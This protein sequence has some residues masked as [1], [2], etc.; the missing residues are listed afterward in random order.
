MLGYN[1]WQLFKGLAAS[2]FVV[3]I[4]SLLL[5][6]FIPAPPSKVTMATLSKALQL[7]ITVGNTGKYWRVLTSNWSC[8]RL[9]GQWR[10]S[11]FS[12][13]QNPAFKLRLWSEVSQT[14]NMHQDCYR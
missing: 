6:Y 2:F 5:I 11:S 13:I 1:R 10:M 7:S 3:G 14:G 12:K 8:A 4:V 9:P